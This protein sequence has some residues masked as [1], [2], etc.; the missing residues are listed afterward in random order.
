MAAQLRQR[1]A[2]K[3]LAACQPAGEP[4]SQH[5]PNDSGS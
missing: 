4:N 3:S 2:H 5:N 1:L